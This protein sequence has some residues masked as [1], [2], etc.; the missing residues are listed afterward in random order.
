MILILRPAVCHMQMP[1]VIDTWR[2]KT[3][4]AI[5]GDPKEGQVNCLTA[6][7]VA[8]PQKK[9]INNYLRFVCA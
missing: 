6:A 8:P 2:K 9:K 1:P 4:A 3:K 7:A 5:E